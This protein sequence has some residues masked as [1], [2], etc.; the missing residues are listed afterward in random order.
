[1][2]E[3]KHLVKWYG[4]ILAVDDI[5]FRVEKGQVVGS[6]PD[7]PDRPH[8]RLLWASDGQRLERPRVVDLRRA[9][10]KVARAVPLP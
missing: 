1:M 10:I 2:I 8:V 4:R 7:A 5:S 3:V 6:N 9:G